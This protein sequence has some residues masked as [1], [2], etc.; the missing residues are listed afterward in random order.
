MAAGVV[1]GVTALM[2]EANAAVSGGSRPKLTPN[3][4]KAALQ[5]TAFP[6][7]TNLG[8]SADMLTVGAGAVNAVGAIESAAGFDTSRPVGERWI[9]TPLIRTTVVGGEML[10]WSESVLWDYAVVSGDVLETNEP[11]WGS[12][13]V[14]G[15]TVVW[16]NA[17]IW[18]NAVVWGNAAVWSSSV[19]WGSDATSGATD[20]TSF[21]WGSL[22]D[23]QE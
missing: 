6:V 19:V 18:S 13:V 17:V 8:V 9:T 14:W 23:I 5:Y 3:A 10:A 12:S 21:V 4:V 22:Y 1:T 7:S 2:V 11:A 16:G 20:G 15:S